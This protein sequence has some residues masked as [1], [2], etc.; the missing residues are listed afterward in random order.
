MG[1]ISLLLQHHTIHSLKDKNKQVLIK[2]GF[3]M[4]KMGTMINPIVFIAIYVLAYTCSAEEPLRDGK[5]SI[6]QIIKFENAPCKGGTR[7][8]TCFTE[9][10]CTDAGGKKDGTC[11]DGFGVCCVT[12]LTNQQSTSLNQSYIVATSSDLS[13][14]GGI[15]STGRYQYTICPCSTDVC[16]TRFD[17]TAF[18]LAGPYT[19]VGTQ[20]ADSSLVTKD[21][22]SGNALGDCRND[23]FS[24][25]GA[26]GSGTPIICGGNKGQHLFVDSNG[27]DCHVVNLNVDST[28]VTRS[29]DIMITQYKCGEEAGGPPGCMQWHM[30]TTGTVRS[31]NFPD[32]TA[33]TTVA[34][35]T[36]HLSN[37]HYDICIRQPISTTYICYQAC[38]NV[39]AVEVAN[40]AATAQTSFGLSLSPAATVGQA[41][42]GS[43]C[44]SDYILIPGGT[45]AAIAQT[46]TVATNDR[47]CGRYLGTLA[48]V[49]A[50]VVSVCTASVPYTIGVHMDD[51]EEHAAIDKGNTGGS[52]QAVAPGGIVGFSL[53]YTTK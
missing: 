50:S 39:A 11:A 6:F 8:G 7:N 26:G 48:T 13:S 27:N 5:F 36:T 53:C 42:A 22:G 28:T 34:A 46:T 15:D 33:G 32:Q 47:F 23:Q 21:D 17:F 20:H 10:E 52:E 14:T 44:T 37:Q 49:Q 2:V 43:S 38:T 30:T 12:K 45:T 1:H 29:L 4:S 51:I 3:G 35:S 9:A 24:V 16:R 31:F 19:N 41:S 18:T 40:G 25:T